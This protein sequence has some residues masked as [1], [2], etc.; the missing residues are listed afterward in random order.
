MRGAVAAVA[1][2][3][4]AA[5][6]G[7][8]SSGASGSGS[9]G[10]G[11]SSSAGSAA[12]GSPSSGPAAASSA[13]S[14]P[15]SSA[16]S[17][18]L[19]KITLASQRN[20]TGFPD[21]LANKLGYFKD[22]GLQVDIK[23]FAS[24]APAIQA[25]ISGAWQAGW[26]GAPPALTAG[27]KTGLITAGLEIEEGPNQVMM[28]RKQDLKGKTP[29]EL[30]K[31]AKV[32]VV[33]NSTSQQVLNGCLEKFG[34]SASDIQVVPLEPP[35]IVQSFQSGQGTV[36]MTWSEVDF[37]LLN[38]SKYEKV[39]DGVDAGVMVYSVFVVQPSFWKSNPT[40]SA[41]YVDA[42]YRANEYIQKNPSDAANLLVEYYKS[43]G[44]NYDV[45]DAKLALSL[46]HWYSLAETI[47]AYKDGTAQKGLAA[48]ADYFVKSGTWTSSPDVRTIVST[49]LKVLEAAQKYRS[50]T[51]R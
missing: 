32:L 23:Y 38:D 42:A 24:G 51:G 46:R 41:A 8:S 44:L 12:P 5:V 33:V 17:G 1:V 4:L 21:W 49:G 6:G 11:P 48:T 7:C 45:N 35:Q 20:A 9:S 28:V 47:S 50:S 2:V 19:T 26:I 31:G 25:G 39:C 40:E 36:A 34:V 14:A 3:A 29:A 30:L 16:P 43:I 13:G 22:N 10:S 27:E 37:P 15:A 18:K